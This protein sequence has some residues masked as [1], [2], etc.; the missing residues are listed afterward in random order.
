[1]PAPLKI[2]EAASLA[3]HAMV[4]LSGQA[5][6]TMS[7]P[8]I[9]RRLRVSGHH[10][11][12]VL[13][14]LGRAGLVASRR[15]PKGGFSLAKAGAEITLLDIYQAVEGPAEEQGCLLGRP[16]CQGGCALGGLRHL[17][18]AEVVGQLARTSLGDLAQGLGKT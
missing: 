16:A 2:S 18:G 17:L 10:L 15:G 14:R 4:L 11:S 1:M 12:K 6:R 3:L 13:Q 9:A 7:T 5:G 8:E